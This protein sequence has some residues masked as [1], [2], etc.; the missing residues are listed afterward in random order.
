MVTVNYMICGWIIFE[1]QQQ[2]IKRQMSVS[3]MIFIMK[4]GNNGKDGLNVITIPAF[5]ISR[6]RY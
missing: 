1:L 2:Y 4:S 6:E 3:D 5:Y